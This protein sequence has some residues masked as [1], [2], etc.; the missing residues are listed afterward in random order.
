MMITLKPWSI[1]GQFCGFM[2]YLRSELI[3]IMV[4][5]IQN[6]GAKLSKITD[7]KLDN[8]R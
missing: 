4:V 3:K 5:K 7:A 6:T 8:V 1:F 2:K